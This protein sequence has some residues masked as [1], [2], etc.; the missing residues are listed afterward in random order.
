MYHAN[1]SGWMTRETFE[2]I[3]IGFV[4]PAIAKKR[5]DNFP[6]KRWA[7]IILD[8]HSSRASSKVL[9]EALRLHIHILTIPSH[10]S[11]LIQALDRGVNAALKAILIAAFTVPSTSASSAFRTEMS[12]VLS[13]SIGK[14]LLGPVIRRAFLAAGI[15]PV[16]SSDSLLRSL[17]PASAQEKAAYDR[18][19]QERVRRHYFDITAQLLT[20]LEMIAACQQR[21]RTEA[22]S[23]PTSVVEA[24]TLK[25]D[26]DA[27]EA[28]GR[29]LADDTDGSTSL[30]S[31]P[32]L[33]SPSPFPSPLL[34][35][36]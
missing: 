22:P 23:Q 14:A 25:Q 13:D 35:S 20:T 32:F 21:E 2:K 4:L 17:S 29:R 3:M 16:S 33:P 28:D 8:S 26:G 24:E 19:L 10:A 31:L 5:D 11:H 7:L 36:T 27:P 15:W 1:K 18:L 30:S 34:S 9:S 6:S 12:V